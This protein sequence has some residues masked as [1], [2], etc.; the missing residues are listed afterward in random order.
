MSLSS[1]E[2][3]ENKTRC[4]VQMLNRDPRPRCTHR[5]LLLD[6]PGHLSPQRDGSLTFKAHFCPVRLWWHSSTLP[7]TPRPSTCL[8][9]W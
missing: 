9:N 3:Y 8:D 4:W 7:F 5:Y 2:A 1:E 6:P